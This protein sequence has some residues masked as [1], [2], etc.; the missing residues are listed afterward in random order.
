MRPRGS[1][2]A[3]SGRRRHRYPVFA[4]AALGIVVAGC[5]ASGPDLSEAAIETA[6]PTW[7]GAAV[8]LPD[9]RRVELHDPDFMA[10]TRNRRFPVVVHLHGSGGLKDVQIRYLAEYARALRAIVV[11][12][13]SYARPNRSAGH[14]RLWDTQRLQEIHFALNALERAPWAD[15]DNLFLMGVSA[16]GIAVAGF[17]RPGFRAAAILGFHCQWFRYAILLPASTPVINAQ[18]PFDPHWYRKNLGLG[19][20]EREIA[21]R[22]GSEVYAFTEPVI[23]DGNAVPSVRERVIAFFRKNLK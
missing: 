23:H 8:F 5:A 6:A 11:A 2:V 3:P 12:P 7:H 19:T 16:G 15:R 1:A 13:D 10:G 9:G 18:N 21:Q 4:L 22:P 20:C 14:T 17:D